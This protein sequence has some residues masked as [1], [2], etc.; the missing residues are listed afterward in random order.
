MHWHTVYQMSIN[1]V[2]LRGLVS[3]DKPV[4]LVCLLNSDGHPQ[5]NVVTNV[6]EIMTKHKVAH[7]QLL[8]GIFQNNDSS[9]RD[10]YSNGKRCERHKGHTT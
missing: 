9:W 1:H 6:Q 10:F 7:L 3:L 2:A 4:K 8:Q 5:E